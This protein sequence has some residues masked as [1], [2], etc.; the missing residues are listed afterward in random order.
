MRRPQ[1][2][3][4]IAFGC[5]FVAPAF[6]A[7]TIVSPP[8]TVT[9]WNVAHYSFTGRC[10]A[11]STIAQGFMVNGVTVSG[12]SFAC[13]PAG[14]YLS[15]PTDLSAL[16]DGFVNVTLVQSDAT[17]TVTGQAGAVTAKATLGASVTLDP[18]V[19]ADATNQ[20]AYPVS[21]TCATPGQEIAITV[22]GTFRVARTTTT[23]IANRYS[24]TLAVGML[25]QGSLVVGA[26]G[27]GT[28][29]AVSAFGVKLTSIRWRQAYSR[30]LA[31]YAAD[32]LWQHPSGAQGYWLM[33]NANAK[34]FESPPGALL[35]LGSLRYPLYSDVL[36]RNASGDYFMTTFPI[37]APVVAFS[38]NVAKVLPPPI[39]PY[40]QI[41]VSNNSGW[42]VV[43]IADFDGDGFEDLLWKHPAQGYGLWLM[44]GTTRLAAGTIAS[45][46]AGFD[47]A[48]VADFDGDGR[49]D[50]LWTHP[51]GSVVMTLM[52]GTS[53]KQ[54]KTM[55]PAGTGWSPAITGDFNADDK[56]DILWKHTDGSW[57]LWLQDGVNILQA[58]VLP[59]RGP[60][61]GW[62]ALYVRDFDGDG[63]GDI[64]WES[65]DGTGA[66]E[67]WRMSGLDVLETK[68]LLAG[69]T[70]WHVYAS[71]DYSGDGLDDLLW[72]TDAGEYG[73]WYMQ[74]LTA[75]T[76]KTLLPAGSGW[77]VVR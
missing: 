74:G 49:N 65:A 4:A 33:P 45:P 22:G 35:G 11:G 28:Q 34:S 67:G 17:P 66:Y 43:R 60:G 44:N 40:T 56:A 5:T 24:T 13:P 53:I 15:T 61:N 32:L 16:P 23:C 19:P 50:L 51:D 9:A 55:L 6:A 1:L 18:P 72:R 54:A 30:S 42:E 41:Y 2:A 21:G 48:L 73:A 69:G 47:V 38:G 63:L 20:A 52:N 68:S 29:V 37:A 62:N 25:P 8:E 59:N 77:E 14:S 58:A 57:G 39:S 64:L 7:L 36:W 75:T 31:G 71:A 3:A 10:D 70:G 46:G 76:T 26:Q 27:V 12:P